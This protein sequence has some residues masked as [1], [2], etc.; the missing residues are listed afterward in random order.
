MTSSFFFFFFN[1][2]NHNYAI[3]LHKQVICFK[4][5]SFKVIV[6]CCLHA[7]SCQKGCNLTDDDKALQN[8]TAMWQ[9]L[10]ISAE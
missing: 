4:L 8:D 1:S 9:E 10:Q 5:C 7:H 3:L 2:K 6:F